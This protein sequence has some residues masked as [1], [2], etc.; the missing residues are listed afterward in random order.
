MNR[1]RLLLACLLLP[2]L[3]PLRAQETLDRVLVVVD[4]AIILESEVGQELQRHLL[5]TRTDPQSLGEERLEQLKF[6]LVQSM[7]DSKVIYAAAKADTNIVVADKEVERRVQNRLDEI[8]RQVG[9]ER[10]LEEMMGQ[11]LKAV[12]HTLGE[13]MRERMFVE[14]AQ[15]RRLGKVEVTRQEVE[16]FH[17]AWQDSLPQVGESVRLSH[18]FLAWKPSAASERRARALADSL[19]AL[20]AADPARFGE[21]AKAFS[22]DAA[23][24]AG[25]GSIGRTKRGSLV[26]PYEEAAYRLETGAITEPVRSDFGWH[27]IR[28][29]ARQGE[30]I[31]SSHILIKLEPT[32]AD[33]QLIYDRADSLYAALQRGADFAAL[34]RAVSDH[35][36]TREGG[37]DLGWLELEQLQPLVRSRVRELKAGEFTRPLRSE[38]EGED[39]MQLIR[40][41][42]HRDA[43]R[44]SLD[45][46]WSQIEQMALNMKRQR[47]LEEWAAELRERVYIRVLD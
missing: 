45:A 32:P 29:D 43:R 16:A 18:I 17:Q 15:R 47:L 34:A 39:G 6:E 42:E 20:L 2:L 44:P 1:L 27:V 46:D 26:R 21:L 31:E 36:L 40:L 7:I 10:R 41:A 22:Q 9:G 38:V 30:Y 4:E 23:S 25:G 8:L 14:E 19:R 37:G 13:S 3:A 35:A 12:R 33:R 28:L 24:A 5:E 11:P